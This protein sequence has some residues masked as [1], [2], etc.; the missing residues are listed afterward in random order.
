[1][2]DTTTS[3]YSFTKPQLNGSADSWGQKLNNNLD[4]LDTLLFED[5]H[6][7]QVQ[8]PTD[9][10]GVVTYTVT[11]AAKASNSRNV[12]NGSSNAYYFNG[13]QAPALILVPGVTYR[14]DLSDSTLTGHPL[15]F[16]YDEAKNRSYTVSE[17]TA[18]GTPGSASAKVEFVPTTNT[19]RALFYGCNSHA[20]M[21]NQ[22][23]VL[24][25]SPKSQSAIV[26]SAPT[27]GTGY[28]TGFVWYVV[29]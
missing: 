10:S 2:S 17:V 9:D 14:F 29:S 16:F 7:R 13:V 3:K 26:T 8:Y 21:G 20:Y 6:F 15:R 22:V 1:M 5:K 24:S 28:P 11:V 27:D 23:E 18:S 12:S 19:P 4:S 25:P